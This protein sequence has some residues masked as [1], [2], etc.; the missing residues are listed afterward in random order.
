[1]V[2]AGYK[3]ANGN[4][5]TVKHDNGFTSYYAHL[6]RFARNLKVGDIVDQKQ[7]IG[8]VGSTGRSTDPTSISG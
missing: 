5:V 1:M 7:I 6:S 8:Y 3:G 2:Y 4:L